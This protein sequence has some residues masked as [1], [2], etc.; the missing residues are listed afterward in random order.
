M[1]L[2]FVKQDRD[3]QIASIVP[4][5]HLTLPIESRVDLADRTDAAQNGGLFFAG[6][7]RWFTRGRAKDILDFRLR[8]AEPDLGEQVVILALPGKAPRAGFLVY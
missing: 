1:Y 6:W 8:H 5:Q 4:K 7:R 2:S 3:A